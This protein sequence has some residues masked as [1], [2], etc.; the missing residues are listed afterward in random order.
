MKRGGM[1]GRGAAEGGWWRRL[2]REGGAEA[3]DFGDFE[4]AVDGGG[5]LAVGAAG[6]VDGEESA[7]E[8]SC[9]GR[10]G[11]GGADVGE[12]DGLAEERD[13]FAG[14][15]AGNEQGVAFAGDV[16]ADERGEFRLRCGGGRTDGGTRRRAS[17]GSAGREDA[18]CGCACNGGRGGWGCHLRARRSAGGEEQG[19]EDGA[20]VSLA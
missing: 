13:G 5:D 19:A 15:A 3:G 2:L 14:G 16:G 11:E 9:G 17:G 8:F 7:P 18:G 10:G 1:E 12:D 6:E 4:R 20:E